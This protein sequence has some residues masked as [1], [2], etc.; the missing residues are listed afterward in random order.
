MQ[1]SA[2]KLISGTS[3]NVPTAW[4]AI[5]PEFRRQ[6]RAAIRINPPRI[7][8][9]SVLCLDRNI[10][11]R[12]ARCLVVP[13]TST[14]DRYCCAVQLPDLRDP[15]EGSTSAICTVDW[16]IVRLSV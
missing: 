16:N 11:I 13:A 2:I 9:R 4:M 12:F 14:E 15:D 8:K 1:M 7:V 6:L 5:E 3:I 10:T